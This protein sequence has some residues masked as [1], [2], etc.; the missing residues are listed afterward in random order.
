MVL[1]GA[2]YSIVAF[3]HWDTCM[4]NTGCKVIAIIG[5]ILAV[6]LGMYSQP[7]ASPLRHIP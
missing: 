5:I 4:A 6:C 3:K 2:N 1:E 7:F